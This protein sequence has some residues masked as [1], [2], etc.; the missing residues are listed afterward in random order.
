LSRLRF[1]SVALLLVITSIQ[2]SA[3]QPAGGSAEVVATLGGH[4]KSIDQI[5]FSHS[6]ELI[7][8]SS[9]DGSV[10]VWR[11]VTGESLTTIT[12]NK[13]SFIYQ[14]AWSSDDRR[15][16]ITYIVKKSWQLVVW[17]VASSQP[18]TIFKD[19]EFVEWSPDG[20][21]FLALDDKLNLQVWDV[22]SR[23][24]TQTFTPAISPSKQ[25]TISFVANGQ[26]ILTAAEGE[27]FQLW[28]VATGKLVNTLPP[29]IAVPNASDTSHFLSAVSLDKRF[30]ISDKANI[31]ETDTGGLITP[32]VGSS[33]VAFGPD[34]KTVLTIRF[35]G[36]D[37]YR[38]RQ[39]YL[40]IRKIDNGEELM[41]FRVPEGISKL[42]WS[43]EGKTLAIEGFEFNTR[44]ID[45]ATGRENGRL[46][47]DNCWPWTPFGSDGCEPTRF[48][49][50]GKMLLKEK[51]PLK[52]W[53]TRNVSLITVLKGAHSPAIFSPTDGQILATRS[54]DKKSILLWRLKR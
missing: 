25:F 14:M 10:R 23:E 32:I 4:T 7:A 26:R 41:A 36:D 5:E 13:N 27:P 18:P 39:S 8:A 47:Y 35:D 15:L 2:L 28:D 1:L 3:Q 34:G 54:E 42:I 48:S 43:P 12:T 50:D 22:I 16:A 6:G 20:D 17:D 21:T 44:V 9:R 37:K 31:H 53:D 51:E 38:H 45:V 11:A 49:A 46:P 19:I 40:S 24:V 30:L 52:L 29:N 33:P